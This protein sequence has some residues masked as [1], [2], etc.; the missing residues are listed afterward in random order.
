MNEQLNGQTNEQL[1]G[2]FSK[3]IKRDQRDDFL[4]DSDTD[5]DM[6][7]YTCTELTKTR[8]Y[9]IE[10]RLRVLQFEYNN[11]V[12]KLKE[13]NENNK[14]N[15]IL[16]KNNFNDNYKIII[17]QNKKINFYFCL[18]LFH[19]LLNLYCFFN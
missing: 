10:E 17:S 2:H 3:K 15:L 12:I 7:T 11:I 14:R 9:D 18:F 5:T 6:Y 19:L 16:N 13:A 8:L 1:N 4:T